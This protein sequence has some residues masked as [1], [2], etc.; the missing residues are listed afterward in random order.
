MGSSFRGWS[1]KQGSI[2]DY[3]QQRQR[4]FMLAPPAHSIF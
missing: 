3:H 2:F 4:S 1:S